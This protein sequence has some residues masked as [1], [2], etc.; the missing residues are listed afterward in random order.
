MAFR[1]C[2]RVQAGE[3]RTNKRCNPLANEGGPHSLTTDQNH[4]IEQLISYFTSPLQRRYLLILTSGR[5]VSDV[6]V[7]YY[8]RPNET[9]QAIYR[10]ERGTGTV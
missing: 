8:H 7:P 1:T 5:H 4:Q 9:A 3:R 6:I 10:G 2:V